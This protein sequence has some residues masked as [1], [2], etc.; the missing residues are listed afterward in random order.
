MAPLA[1]SVAVAPEQ[2]VAEL[3]VTVGIGLTVNTEVLLPEHPEVVPVT[4]YV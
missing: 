3:T 2:T 4:V 1:V